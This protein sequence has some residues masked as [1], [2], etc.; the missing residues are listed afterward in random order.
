MVSTMAPNTAVY[1]LLE[2]L[3]CRWYFPGDF[4]QVVPKAATIELPTLDVT[5]RPSFVVRNIWCSGWADVTR[6]P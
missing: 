4:G 5:G 6:R 3:G 1:D 2:R